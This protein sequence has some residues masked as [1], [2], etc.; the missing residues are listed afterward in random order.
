AVLRSI[1]Y[2]TRAAKSSGAAGPLA[3]LAR[4]GDLLPG[5]GRRAVA[6]AAVRAAPFNAVISNVAGPPV[7]LE[8]LGRRL[9]SVHPA[10]PLLDGHALSVGALS[11]EGR[12]HVGLYADLVVLPEVAE[13]ARDLES[14]FDALRLARSEE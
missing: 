5:P 9:I 4:G 2:V 14:A 6:R 13:V 11:Y 8:L 3:A 12:L 10:V 7:A 1:R